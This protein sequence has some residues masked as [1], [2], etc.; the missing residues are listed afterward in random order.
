MADKILHQLQRC[1]GCSYTLVGQAVAQTVFL[2]VSMRDKRERGGKA[3]K[4]LQSGGGGGSIFWDDSTL[5]LT[6]TIMSNLGAL[7]NILHLFGG[8]WGKRGG[9]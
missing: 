2:L 3:R 9:S 1:R 7:G 8:T 5:G 4:I 6:K